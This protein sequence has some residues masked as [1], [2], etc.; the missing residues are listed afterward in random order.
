MMAII[1]DMQIFAFSDVINLSITL[2]LEE[3]SKAGAWANIMVLLHQFC[4]VERLL[5]EQ[6]N[7]IKPKKK[8]VAFLTFKV[9]KTNDKAT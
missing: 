3:K 8:N 9:V 6:E 7:S 2:W 1:N 5:G 4:H